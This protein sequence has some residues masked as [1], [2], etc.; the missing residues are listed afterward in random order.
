MDEFGL[1]NS[2]NFI[3]LLPGGNF[4]ID[5]ELD[6]EASKVFSISKISFNT[7]NADDINGIFEMEF[8]SR[9]LKNLECSLA[10][11]EL[12]DFDFAYQLNL[13]DEWV[14]GSANCAGSTCVIAEMDHLVRT[15]DT[16][17]IFTILNRANILNPLYSIYLYGAI[18]SGQKINGGH[19]LKFQF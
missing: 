8:R 14:R 19:E 15:S 17:N 7:V 3:G 4:V 16:V 11:C 2:D 9:P 10:D 18:S 6:K 1:F 12:S 5:L 13:N